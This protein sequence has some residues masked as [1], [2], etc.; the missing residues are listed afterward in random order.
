MHWLGGPATYDASILS[1]VTLYMWERGCGMCLV[2]VK[3]K[4]VV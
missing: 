2:T 1:T 3:Y 4:S